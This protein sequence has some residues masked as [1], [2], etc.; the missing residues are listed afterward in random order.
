MLT[1]F[2]LLSSCQ[3]D[4]SITP[5]KSTVSQVALKLQLVYPTADRPLGANT[6]SRKIQ[7]ADQVQVYVYQLPTLPTNR[8]ALPDSHAYWDTRDA[9]IWAQWDG[10]LQQIRQL[11][12][13]EID[14]PLQIEGNLARGTVRVEVGA[15]YL[16][17]GVFEA[18]Q[19]IYSGE[20]W[21]DAQPGATPPIAVPLTTFAPNAPPPEL[22]TNQIPLANAGA[23]Q[24][25]EVGQTVTLDGSASSDPDGDTLTYLWTADPTNPAPQDPVTVAQF[26][27]T[28][29]AVG[30]YRFI[31]TVNDGQEPSLPDTLQV[32]ANPPAPVNQPPIANAGEDQTVEIGQTVT[33]DGSASSDPDGD[34]LTY[35]WTADANNPASTN[36]QPQGQFS[37]TPDTKGQY[38]FILT[39][40][41]GNQ[42]SQP[43]TVEIAVNNQPPVV[44]L[45]AEETV[46]FSTQIA[47]DGQSST[48]PDG[49][50]L[51]Y[52]WEVVQAPTALELP[53]PNAAQLQFLPPQ[54]G[55]YV[56]RLTV[57]DGEDQS[58]TEFRLT[59]PN[60]PPTADA[61]PDQVLTLG[62]E[63]TVDGS[64]SFDPEGENLSFTW[65]SAP[66]NPEVVP[67][68][69][70][71][72]FAFTPGAAGDYQLILT[73]NDG[74]QDSIADTVQLTVSGPDNGAPLADAGPDKTINLGDETILDGILSQDPD[75]DLITYSWELA[76]G[77]APVTL[78][79]P[80]AAQTTFRPQNSGIYLFRLS[81]SDGDLTTSD[82]VQIE[83]LNQP[84]LANAGPDQTLVLGALA[85]LSGAS[86]TDP[87]GAS[88][89]YHWQGDAANPAFLDLP[90]ALEF[91]LLPP[92]SGLYR[93]ILVVNDGEL[94]SAPDTVEIEVTNTAP[95]FTSEPTIAITPNGTVTGDASAVTDLEGHPIAHG[96]SLLDG[97]A[98]IDLSPSAPQIEFTAPL[99]GQYI[100]QVTITDGDLETTR[101]LTADIISLAPTAD[102]GPDQTVSA[103]ATLTLDGSASTDPDDHPL[104]FEWTAS[105]D[106]PAVVALG[107][108]PSFTIAPTEAG[109]YSFYLQVND[110]TYTSALDTV[111]ITVEANELQINTPPIADAGPD[112]VGFIG[113]EITLDGSASSDPEGAALT[114]SWSPVN[115]N[116][117]A[118]AAAD[119]PSFSFTPT[120]RGQYRF[121]LQVND[122]E[123]TSVSDSVLVDILNQAPIADA[124]SDLL[125]RLDFPV[126]LD[127][128][129][130]SD[131]EGD[132]LTY[133]WKV[134]SGPGD[135]QLDNATSQ[136]PS[137]TGQALG[138]YVI[139]LVV[140]D[141]QADSLPV[142][143]IVEVTDQSGVVVTGTVREDGA[144]AEVSGTINEQE[145][146]DAEVS[147]NVNE[148]ETADAEVSG[149]INEQETAGA[150]I[151]GEIKD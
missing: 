32:Q 84:P 123:L 12:A 119:A 15:K 77:P 126:E 83:V 91:D 73:V 71:A 135:A 46:D 51:F 143:L 74:Q 57:S 76:E 137:F 95:T 7:A 129:S 96:W 18:G 72:I 150:E 94:D 122:G 110:G 151:T 34:S 88:L 45:D 20:Q 67:V 2:I 142:Q 54:S 55:D 100:L 68:Q 131:L 106:N 149:T 14:T 59:V 107:D 124:G 19:L 38:R 65:S 80:T 89:N 29:N 3:Q 5:Q 113:E 31:L 69:A 130:S 127:G 1:A 42:S 40:S 60:P 37:F 118:V 10:F 114:F 52:L 115:G 140:S 139:E 99:S 75:G 13:P 86:S 9:N 58:S 121:L 41:D 11:S 105:T 64:A 8:P 43:D 63:A 82:E 102:A 49:D 87:E 85:Q 39:V 36:T 25:V 66:T 93:F 47:L 132:P 23:D 70:V 24:T 27:F 138:V 103:G 101:Q 26:D 21:V 48:D 128:G 79:E 125:I 104:S 56:F 33:L 146:A 62:Q 133:Q 44:V 92:R 22:P 134:L 53:D 147:G 148:E 136:Q 141:G 28:P 50:T 109:L 30:T 108:T 4:R 117:M 120:L 61:G 112:Q 145:T 98:A 78:A 116:P 144:D 16:F 97:P 81:V 90:A 6:P 111:E 35:L 17:V